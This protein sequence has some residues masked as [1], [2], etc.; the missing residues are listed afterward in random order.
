[1]IKD[2]VKKLRFYYLRKVKWREFKIGKNMYVGLRVNLWAKQ[3][4]TIGDNFYMGRDSQIETDCVIG[5]NV[6]FGN[7]VAIV[8]KYDHNFKQLGV[9]VRLAS[10]IRDA[11]YN[12]KRLDCIT[13]IEDCLIGR[14]LQKIIIFGVIELRFISTTKTFQ[15]HCFEVPHSR[16]N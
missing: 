2:L 7:K 16:L 1:M 9:P 5:D 15:F 8:G 11:D 4:L 6:M 13:I 14:S 3:T 10:S 12:W